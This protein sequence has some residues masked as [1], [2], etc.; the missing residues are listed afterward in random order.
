MLTNVP[1][2][3]YNSLIDSSEM[4]TQT[5][6]WL[7]YKIVIPHPLIQSNQGLATKKVCQLGTGYF[8]FVMLATSNDIVKTA[9]RSSF[10][11]SQCKNF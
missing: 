6:L 10:R 3:K 7:R 1:L 11:G 8:S 9:I 4:I 5:G 2:K